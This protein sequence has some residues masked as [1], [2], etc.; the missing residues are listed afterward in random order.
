MKHLILSLLTL[1]S[2]T[3][4]AERIGTWT[5][6]PSYYGITQV[7]PAGTDIFVLASGN[8]YSFHPADNS[9]TTYYKD[10]PLSD[11]DGGCLSSNDIRQ[12]AWCGDAGDRPPH[13]RQGRHDIHRPRRQADGWRQEHI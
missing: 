12:I 13:G 5:L 3:A 4:A 7:A 10:D 8:L 2:L 1:L 11:L 6:F 9:L